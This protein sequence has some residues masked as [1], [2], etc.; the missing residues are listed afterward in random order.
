MANAV[1][2]KNYTVYRLS[3]PLGGTEYSQALSANATRINIA[4]DDLTSSLQFSFTALGS[5]T[6]K[7]IFA[8]GE[9]TSP[10]FIPNAKTLFVQTPNAGA[11]CVIE[12]WQSP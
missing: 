2:I 6:G 4:T 7:K 12:E 11:V 8:G 5:G 9:W 1:H 3:L 10:G